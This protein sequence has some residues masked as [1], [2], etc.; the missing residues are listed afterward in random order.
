MLNSRK[1]FCA[2]DNFFSHQLLPSRYW[3]E[4]PFLIRHSPFSGRRELTILD[5]FLFS[6]CVMRIH[7]LIHPRST[8]SL[9]GFVSGHSSLPC[10]I[11]VGIL[12]G[13]WTFVFPRV[14]FFAVLRLCCCV[15]FS[16]LLILLICF[17]FICSLMNTF[18][19]FFLS[20]FFC[21]LG[22]ERS[23]TWKE[24]MIISQ[25]YKTDTIH[26]CKCTSAFN[27]QTGVT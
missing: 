5:M 10:P 11:Y 6:H 3:D 19:C 2:Q 20:F 18:L 22:K 12:I 16:W 15:I 27:M 9:R 14:W 26:T 21:I 17:L 4:I 7:S 1:R 13:I 23:K 24:M 25:F 8:F